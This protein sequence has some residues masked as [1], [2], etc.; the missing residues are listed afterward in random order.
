MLVVARG[1]D[2]LFAKISLETP[3]NLFERVFRRSS[4]WTV[5]SAWALSPE[6]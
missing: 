4:S 3:A 6:A 1:D 2:L 5:S